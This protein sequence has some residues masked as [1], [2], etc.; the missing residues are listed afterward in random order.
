[1]RRGGPTVLGIVL[2]GGEGKRL[3][4]LTA[5]RA[6]P[7]VTFGG[8]YRLVDFVLSNLVNADI[9]RICVLTQYKSHSLDR[10]ITTTWRMSSL[11]GNY[12]TPVP[13]QQRLG[14]RWYLGSADAILQSLNLIYDERPEYVAVFG[15]DH[16]YRMD[17]RQMLAQHIESGAGVTVAG[18]RVPRGESSSFGVI[19]PGSDGQSVERF[20][21]KPADPPGLVDDPESVFASMGNYIF[22]TKALIEALQRDAEDEAS[23]HDMG[24]SIL[25][26]LTERGEAGLYDFSENHVPGETTR[27]QGYWRDVG[28]LDAYYDAHMDLIAERPAFNLYNRSWP[29]YTHSGQLSPARFNAGG[30]AGESIISSGCLIRGQVTRSVL[31]PGVVVDPG[32]V[33]QGSILHDNVHIGRGAVVRGAVL[34]KNVDVPPGATIGVNPERDAEL[35]TVSPGGVIA[36]GKGCRVS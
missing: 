21:E 13:A 34:D 7:A 2:A 24:G 15:A 14:P 36:L 4:P 27:D 1:M 22:T 9:L 10:H 3:M 31:S 26:Q 23:V 18:I 6:K 32:A 11:L 16:V 5:D 25:P 29:I 8:T 28:T 30:I 35:Y 12:V 19:T 20:L 33:V 17:P